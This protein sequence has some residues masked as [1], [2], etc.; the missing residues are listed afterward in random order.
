MG[1]NLRGRDSDAADEEKI[2]TTATEKVRATRQTDSRR[3]WRPGSKDD[4]NGG[5]CEGNGRRRR[6][7]HRSRDDRNDSDNGDGDND[8][9]TECL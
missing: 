8:D 4:D 3:R 7:G 1:A 6:S 5:G 9:L 2:Q